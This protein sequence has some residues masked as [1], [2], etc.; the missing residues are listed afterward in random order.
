MSKLYADLGGKPLVSRVLEAFDTVRCVQEMVVAVVPETKGRFRRQ[1][2]AGLGL[3]RPVFLVQGGKTRAQSVWNALKRVSKRSAYVAIH[4]GARPLVQGRWLQALLSS[5]NGWD[6]VVLGRPLTATVKLLR[7]GSEEIEETLGRSQLFEAET[8]QLFR[9][10]SL[11]HSYRMLGAHAL[12]MTDDASLVEAAGGRL[13]A[14]PH[15][16]PNLKVTTYQDLLWVRQML[17]GE[18]AKRFGLGEDRHRL[19]PGRPFFL[20]GV[21]IP[22]PT[23]PLGHSDGDV[24]LH[25]VTDA[26]LG[27]V[28]A[29]DIGDLFPDTDKRWKGASSTVFL[30]RAVRVAGQKGFRPS[31]VDATVCL[32]RP[33]LSTAKE[34]I[35]SALAKQLSLAEDRISI[36]AKT[37]EGLGGE[38]NARSV[39]ARVLVVLERKGI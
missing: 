9:K 4:D 32:D 8:P 33:K 21:R 2:L 26:I 34:K 12:Q 16:E 30:G 13:R 25:A 7:A 1:V 31:Q 17:A 20:G 29:G 15:T 18:P 37:S 3:K 19:V 36:K 22:S 27:A 6:G 5:L 35:R 39:S 23:G 14:I 28:A 10:A 24:L 38:A 11:I